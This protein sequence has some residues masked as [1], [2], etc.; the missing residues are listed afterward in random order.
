MAEQL[1]LDA[2][3]ARPQAPQP[4]ERLVEFSTASGDHAAAVRYLARLVGFTGAGPAARAAWYAEM[5]R[6][7]RDHL[8]DPE[9]A[10]ACFQQALDLDS[11]QIESFGDCEELIEASA[12]WRALEQ[13]HRRMLARLGREGKPNVR[14]ALWRN[15]AELYR[16]RLDDPDRALLAAE[17]VCDLLPDSRDSFLLAEEIAVGRDDLDPARIRKLHRRLLAL[18]PGR[19][20]SVRALRRVELRAGRV[21]AAWLLCQRLADAGDI[22]AGEESYLENL[23]RPGLP[24][25]ARPLTDELWFRYVVHPDARTNVAHLLSLAVPA[26]LDLYANDPKHFGAKRKHWIDPG[27]PLLLSR[28]L[29]ELSRALGMPEPPAAYTA[30]R[31]Q[32]LSVAAA[33]PP[34]VLVGPDMLSGRAHRDLAF[35]LART[36]ALFR[37]D[38][39]PTVYVPEETLP[40]LV[41][42]LVGRYSPDLAVTRDR[43]VEQV[44]RA[45]ER[46][47]D[48]RG[49]AELKSVALRIVEVGEAAL[50]TGAYVSGVRSS[51]DRVG[52][53][54]SEDLTAAVESIPEER[55]EDLRAWAISEEYVAVR[56]ALGLAHRVEDDG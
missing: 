54:F 11:S 29:S 26:L 31:Q 20:R 55:R 36:L 4:W 53:L 13:H 56:D 9:A 27:G 16:T 37:P 2:A 19:V 28:L 47:L 33:S 51:C 14:A 23:R 6:R 40:W 39:L 17:A 15:L 22:D 30:K 12:D 43:T 10:I 7:Y 8:E 32:G 25:A 44:E 42:C 48:A 46:D 50:D 1:C 5:A 38:F 45:L 24:Q 21:D 34:I 18:E 52:L 35:E 41:R 49:Q 3:A